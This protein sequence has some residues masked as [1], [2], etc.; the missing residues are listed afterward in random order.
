MTIPIAFNQRMTPRNDFFDDVAQAHELAYDGLGL[1]EMKLPDG[2]DER[3]VTAMGEAGLAATFCTPSVWPIV[4]GPLDQAGQPKDVAGRVDAICKSIERF[5]K[6]SPLGVVV[7]GGRSGDPA[8][9][10]GTPDE[11]AAPLKEIAK[12]ASDNG[13][14]VALEVMPLRKGSGIP[15]L[16]TAVAL[17]DELAM[18]NV[19]LLIDVQHVWDMQARD[20]MLARYATRVLYFQLNDVRSPERTWADRLLPGD[21]LGHAGQIAAALGR[22]GYADWCE[23][24][25]FS[26]DGTF[27]TELDDSLWTMPHVD[28]LRLGKTRMLETLETVGEE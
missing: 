19:G 26:D 22:G 6:F 17:L 13:M 15:D 16:T 11:I 24:E 20:E 14:D 25:I 12:V 7:G 9:P 8:K 18:P 1:D 4:E 21:G 23:L 2:I 28:L 5:K 3:A 27:G 10:A